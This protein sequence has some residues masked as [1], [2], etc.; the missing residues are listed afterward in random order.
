VEDRRVTV[1]EAAILLGVSEGAIRKRVDRGTLEHDKGADGRVCV[2]LPSGIYGVD[3]GVDPSN[4]PE[5]GVLIS[6]MKERIGFLEEELRRKDAILLNMT[7][8]M[9]ALTPPS[10]PPSEPREVPVSASGAQGGADVHPEPREEDPE[11]VSAA[12]TEEGEGV[13]TPLRQEHRPWWRR[14]FGP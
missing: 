11:T 2:Y 10:D 5:S 3:N 8:A 7:E 4:T 9:K 12:S 14:L 13:E 1:R 6:E